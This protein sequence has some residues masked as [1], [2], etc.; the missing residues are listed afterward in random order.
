MHDK[1]SPLRVGSEPLLWCARR[2]A[3][4]LLTKPP[5]APG[6]A[7]AISIDCSG[8]IEYSFH[9]S[10]LVYDGQNEPLGYIYESASWLTNTTILFTTS[11]YLRHTN[12]TPLIFETDEMSTA[13]G[14]SLGAHIKEE[15]TK[16]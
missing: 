9:S 3:L 5:K 1:L 2:V 15:D 8:H 4:T 14:S 11:A 7:G 13:G 12:N 16:G 6:K 10:K